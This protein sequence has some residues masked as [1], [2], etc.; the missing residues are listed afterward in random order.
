MLVD[1]NMVLMCLYVCMCTRHAGDSCS[2]RDLQAPL[3]IALG[4]HYM[5]GVCQGVGN[6]CEELRREEF[7]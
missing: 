1:E 5:L 7:V 2:V 6:D 3:D 4:K